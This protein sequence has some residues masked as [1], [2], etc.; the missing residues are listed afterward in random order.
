MKYEKEIVW[1]FQKLSTLMKT[2][3][4]GN[5]TREM[6]IVAKNEQIDVEFLRRGL[7]KGRII[8]LVLQKLS[9]ILMKK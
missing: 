5:L 6:E 7:E 8:M 9:V 2:A 3:R 1:R 4:N